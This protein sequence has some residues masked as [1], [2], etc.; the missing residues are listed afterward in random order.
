MEN[1]S[2]CVKFRHH[3]IHQFSQGS[4]QSLYHKSDVQKLEKL[5][6]QLPQKVVDA[7]KKQ[8]EE[9]NKILTTDESKKIKKV[10]DITEE[11]IIGLGIPE[12]K[13]KEVLKITDKSKKFLEKCLHDIIIC[14]ENILKDIDGIPFKS[15]KLNR[16]LNL[17]D[18]SH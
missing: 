12:N 9:L 1:H 10:N 16:F 8:D 6:T 14:R 3:S 4:V 2:K 18:L 13:A 11:K 7:G 17:K 5:Q 15:E